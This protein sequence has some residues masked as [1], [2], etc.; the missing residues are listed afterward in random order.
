L[1][2]TSLL[3]CPF[4]GAGNEHPDV[5]YKVDIKEEIG[6]S[7]W[8]LARRSFD[9]ALKEGARYI[10]IHL[11][12]YGGTVIHADSLRSMILRC[13]VPVWVFVDNNAASAGA[14]ISIACDR[15]YMSE[16]ASIGAAT[17]VD[18]TGEKQ[19]DKV[20]SYMR[21]MMRA[22]AQAKGMDTVTVNGERRI[23]WRRDPAIAEAMV[24]EEMEVDG[25]SERGKVVSFTAHEAMEHGF[26]D[27]VAA[28]VEEVIRREGVT[29]YE[30]REYRVTAL[31]RLIGFLVHP[32]V[33]GLLIM[34]IIGGIY[35]ELQTPGVGFPLVAAVTAC[36]LY[37][38]PLYLEGLATY[39]EIIL[40]VVGVILLLL[41]IFVIPGFG[42]AGVSGIACI[43]G[44][45]ALAGMEEFSFDF[46]GEF[47]NDLIY[48]L[49]FVSSCAALSLL[50]SLWLGRKLFGLRGLRLALHATTPVEEGFVGVDMTA[51]KEIGK[52]GTAFTSLRPAGKVL[53]DDEVYDAVS[54]TGDYIEKGSRVKVIKFQSG[55]LYVEYDKID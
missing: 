27:G 54:N 53:V 20:Q 15:I 3:V 28:S 32:V 55:Q 48:S 51:R 23:S 40:F 36:A 30:L 49:F 44:S 39:I 17:V 16:G 10:V 7:S 46:A 33:Q 6:A 8:R 1:L 43:M 4:P 34:I 12:T 11:N 9:Q 52:R 2:L 37:F 5:V 14:L 31:D 19:P 24:D 21:S 26:C 38:S 22:T 45:L 50:L 41:E 42:I 18:G 47:A 25:V 35:F 13:P 29:R